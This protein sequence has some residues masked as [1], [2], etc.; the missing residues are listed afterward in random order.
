MPHV[1]MYYALLVV[2]VY[3]ILVVLRHLVGQDEF[4]GARVRWIVLDR[5]GAHDLPANAED[6]VLLMRVPYCPLVH[7]ALDLFDGPG[8]PIFQTAEKISVC[9]FP[10]VERSVRNSNGGSNFP[11]RAPPLI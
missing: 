1:Y 8:P 2:D 7:T 6:L 3:L 11:V 5:L 4:A 10:V 9:F